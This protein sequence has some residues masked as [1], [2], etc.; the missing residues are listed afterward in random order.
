VLLRGIAEGRTL[1]FTKTMLGHS[2]GVSQL[3]CSAAARA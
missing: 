2:K 3:H 1:D